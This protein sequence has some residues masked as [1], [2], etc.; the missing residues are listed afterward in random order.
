M[1]IEIFILDESFDK[2]HVLLS[3]SSSDLPNPQKVL[4]LKFPQ[5]LRIAATISIPQCRDSAV[6]VLVPRHAVG[7]PYH[8]LHFLLHLIDK[9]LARLARRLDRRQLILHHERNRLDRIV[10]LGLDH[11]Q[12][13]VVPQCR[14]WAQQEKHVGRLDARYAV[15]GLGIL[16]P[17]LEHVA[18][19]LAKDVPL[20]EQF[21]DIEP[22]C[23]DQGIDLLGGPV[24]ERDGVALDGLDLSRVDLDVAP[25]HSRVEI[26]GDNNAATSHLVV[27][28]QLSA[29]AL[30]LDL[31][32]AD[33]PRAPDREQADELVLPLGAESADGELGHHVEVLVVDPVE[34]GDVAEKEPPDG[35]VASVAAWDDVCGGPLVKLEGLDLVDDRGDYLDGT[36]K[37][38]EREMWFRCLRV[39]V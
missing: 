39:S 5:S 11:K 38:R 16:A 1:N 7:R 20:G 17:R 9:V 36:K 33:Q 18:A 6:V 3:V 15:V 14:I 37:N 25:L 31:G 29:Q 27:W 19:V 30:V 21:K 13:R 2:P 26:R 34:E 10:H 23:K 12:H 24:L 22:S 28:G 8:P 32:A 35:V 4:R